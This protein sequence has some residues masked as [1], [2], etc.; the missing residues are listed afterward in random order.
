MSRQE[1]RSV[2]VWN[3]DQRQAGLSP[4]RRKT[5]EGEIWRQESVI[6]SVFE[7]SVAIRNGAVHPLIRG[8]AFV[9]SEA[10]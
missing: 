7:G 1:L 2:A 3:R 5:A 6:G 10:T 4:R 8:S 9:N